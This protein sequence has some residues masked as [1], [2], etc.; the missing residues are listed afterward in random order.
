[1]EYSIG[2]D[3]MENGVDIR[4]AINDFK[5]NK[6]KLTIRGFNMST[7]QCLPKASHPDRYSIAIIGVIFLTCAVSLVLQAYS[8]RLSAKI[9]NVFYEKKAEER[10]RYL[11]NRI[12]VGRTARRHQLRRVVARRVKAIKAAE[13]ISYT[14]WLG[15]CIARKLKYDARL[16]C[17][18]CRKSIKAGQEVAFTVTEDDE[19]LECSICQDCHKEV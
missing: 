14:T 10:A 19:T 15:R 9:C 6:K 5:A 12:M 4:T 8:T 17:P 7:A 1:M 16:E 13:E 2:F 18:G 11:Y 3:G